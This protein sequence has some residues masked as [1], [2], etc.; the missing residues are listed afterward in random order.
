MEQ[1]IDPKK[2]TTADYQTGG[3]TIFID[4]DYE[5]KTAIKLSG[6]MYDLVI[7]ANINNVFTPT[8]ELFSIQ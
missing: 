5:D 7:G 1:S 8:E 2:E 4:A 6:D 3:K